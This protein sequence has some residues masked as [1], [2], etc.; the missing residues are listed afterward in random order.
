[1]A[2]RKAAKGVAKIGELAV[3]H[4]L[5]VGGI[6]AGKSQRAA[7]V[8]AGYKDTPAAEYNACQLISIDKVRDAIAA[9]LPK[10]MPRGWQE[11]AGCATPSRRAGY[12]S[13]GRV[14]ENHA[15][16][17]G[18]NG[19]SKPPSPPHWPRPPTRQERGVAL[20]DC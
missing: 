19:G 7:Y 17:M 20:R 10:T 9:G 8:A 16:R 5:F 4:Q 2:K 12:K 1:M 15:S 3:K 18:G 13:T 14:A 6:L 11:M